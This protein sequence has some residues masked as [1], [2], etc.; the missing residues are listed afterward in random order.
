MASRFRLAIAD[1]LVQTEQT[2]GDS[3]FPCSH[4]R[5][6]QEEVWGGRRG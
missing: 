3:A 6:G 4:G 1:S 2:E 5:R